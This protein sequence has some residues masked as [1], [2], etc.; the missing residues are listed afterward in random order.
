MNWLKLTQF[1][2]LPPPL[3]LI[4]STESCSN[5]FLFGSLDKEAFTS[6]IT[7]SEIIGIVFGVIGALALVTVLIL[8]CVKKGTLWPSPYKT[9]SISTKQLDLPSTPSELIETKRDVNGSCGKTNDT[10]YSRVV[11]KPPEVGECALIVQHLHNTVNSLYC[12]HPRDQEL[13]WRICK[14]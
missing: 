5:I 9:R 8:F 11:K 2:P 14:L 3:Q 7:S 13:V 10:Q 4:G 12:G 1:E 6:H